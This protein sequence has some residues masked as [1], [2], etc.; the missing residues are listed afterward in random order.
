M[1][2]SL[3]GAFGL[4]LGAAAVAVAQPASKKV[5]IVSVTGC[6]REQAPGTWMLVA[7][8]EPVPSLANAPSKDE[9]PTAAPAGKLSFRLIGVGEFSLPTMKDKTAVVRGLLIRDTP[10]SRLNVTSVVEALPACAD[11]APK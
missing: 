3:V 6:L 7:A 4:V 1:R 8:T 9:L 11:G 2:T 10:T 5:D